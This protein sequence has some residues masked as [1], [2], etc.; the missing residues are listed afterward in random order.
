MLM[1]CLLVAPLSVPVL[2]WISLPAVNKWAGGKHY[3]S[4]DIIF[5]C[6]S[7]PFM[8]LGECAGCVCAVLAATKCSM[9][10]L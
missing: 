5:D 4:E 7:L 8:A 3:G 2:F 1:L 10:L 6:L 9:C